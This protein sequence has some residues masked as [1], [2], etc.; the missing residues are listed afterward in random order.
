MASN[1]TNGTSVSPGTGSDW[2]P[3]LNHS[4]NVISSQIRV[5]VS[6]L[7]KKNFKSSVTELKQVS[8]NNLLGRL[9]TITKD[10]IDVWV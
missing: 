8:Q 4:S 1:G 6:G 10:Y 5:L 7:N 2:N 9:L 3:S